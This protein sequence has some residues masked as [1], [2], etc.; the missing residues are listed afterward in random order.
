M[1][2][3]WLSF[4]CTQ[5][6]Q[7]TLLIPLIPLRKVKFFLG[8]C[9]LANGLTTGYAD[10]QLQN[11]L[12][13]YW[14]FNEGTGTAA[15]DSSGDGNTGILL[16]G[17]TWSSGKSGLA[18]AFDGTNDYVEIPH[19]QSLNLSTALTVSVWINNET[20]MD[21]GLSQDQYR[22]IASKGWPID[23]GSWS[24]A[25]RA[26]DA[27]LFFFV[28]RNTIYRYASFAYDN[29]QAGTW[30]LITAVLG[31]GTISLYQDG[32]LKAGPVG[33]DSSSIRTEHKPASRWFSGCIQ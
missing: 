16:N 32:V 18:L 31:N 27:S 28:G 30:H 20:L 33:I 3:I 25:W 6:R 1:P 23:G 2:K 4:S 13:G 15:M 7:R 17:P 9:L 19:A 26:N 11:G 12:V 21:P 14:P 24:L 29:S 5:P 10:A 22:I 8:A